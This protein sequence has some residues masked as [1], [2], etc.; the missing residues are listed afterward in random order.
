[1]RLSR[2]G[3]D[4]LKHYEGLR[5]EAYIC[6]AGVWTIGYG[7]TR[8]ARA[9]MK[10]T[11]PEADALLVRDVRA[12]EEAV[13]R[14][15]RV[16]LEQ[17]E[18]DAL[19]C[20]AFNVGTKAFRESALVKVLNKGRKGDVPAQLMRWVNAGGKRLKG[21]E[22]RRRSEAGLWRDLGAVCVGEACR[23]VPDVPTPAKTLLQSKTAVAASLGT[24]VGTLTAVNE[25]VQTARTTIDSTL[26]LAG[27]FN[28]WVLAVLVIL[29]AGAFILWDRHQKLQE[30]V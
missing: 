4:L 7:H 3:F 18:F 29:A 11:E 10:I 1:M 8:T 23:V 9:G 16:P 30:G 25:A 2:S 26:S 6:P 21:L 14:A 19:V 5:L 17:H 24:G 27:L 13:N 12:F 22:N 20:F 28:P 15:V